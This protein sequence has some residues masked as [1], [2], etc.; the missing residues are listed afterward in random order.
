MSATSTCM[1]VSTV[2]TYRIEH[3]FYPYLVIVEKGFD[4][5]SN[6]HYTH[7]QLYHRS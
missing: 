1:Y 7:K 2:V 4:C 3:Y 6:G 5:F